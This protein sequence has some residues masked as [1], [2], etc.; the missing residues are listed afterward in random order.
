MQKAVIFDMDGVLFDT[1]KIC[2]ETWER[3]GIERGL[4]GV[5]DVLTATTGSNRQDTIICLK[6]SYGEDFDALEFLDTCAERNINRMKEEGV[7]IKKGVPEILD[8]LRQNG[9][10]IGLASSSR[11]FRVMENLE[12]TGLTDYFDI[13]VGGDMIKHS[14]PN[15][16]IYILACKELG[17]VPEETFAIE[18]SPNG[19]RS[20][21]AA[22]M[23]PIMVPDLLAPTEEIL[24]MTV[25]CKEDLTEVILYLQEVT[26]TGEK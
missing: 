18:D 9:F 7:P 23:Q 20:A 1:E 4:D 11:R 22:G 24:S 10:K 5:L 6:E 16:D 2:R 13:I 8:Y 19:I 15:P 17:V 3:I 14:K 25:A 12:Q 21:Y 26:K